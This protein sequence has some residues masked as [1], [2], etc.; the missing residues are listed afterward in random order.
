[1][2]TY[3]V[4]TYARI[5]QILMFL[6]NKWES[7]EMVFTENGMH[8][9]AVWLVISENFFRVFHL[10][11]LPMI[12]NVVITEHVLQGMQCCIIHTAFSSD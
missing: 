1:M 9:Y 6:G 8:Y 12:S 10:T 4:E 3:L 11:C 5:L 2:L 7:V